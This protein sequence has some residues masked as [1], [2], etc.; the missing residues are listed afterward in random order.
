MSALFTPFTL[1]DV[2][3][4]N[5]IAIPPMCQ[6]SA[7]EGLTT[8]WHQ[9]HYPALARGGAGLVIVEATAVSPEGRI[10]PACTGLWNDQQAE[11]MAKIA[12]SIKAAGAVP[13]IQIGHAGRKA[14]ANRPWEGDDHIAAGDSRG[15]ATLAPS[16]VAFGHHL[17]QVPKAMTLDDITRV[18]SDFVAAARRARDAGFEWLELHF[19]HGYLAQSFFSVHAN[20]RNDQ[21]GGD[22]AGR[23][24]FLLETLAAVREVW[25][26]NL[27][28]T[29]RF[30]V[31]EYDG[32][33]EQTLAESIE[34]T[35]LMRDG[36]LDLLNVSVGFTIAETEI[37]WGSAFLAPVAERVRREAGLPVASSWG[38]EAPD[39]AERVIAEQ[40]MDLVMIGRAHLANPHYPYYLA[41]KLNV[42]RPS[43]VLPAPYA[44]WLERYRLG[45]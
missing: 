28:L 12:A 10:T 42:E 44:H 20:Q 25:P 30:G 32:R 11:G 45:E 18:K 8:D 15:W 23:S 5:R 19:A 16:A 13:G 41:K 37:P 4:R 38:I 21:Y 26:E 40:Q 34:L 31:I 43:W 17:P 39:V 36:G 27:P 33:D 22:F 2:T 24:R 7:E 1:K 9:V 14:S 29:A 6:Y 35:R 3:L